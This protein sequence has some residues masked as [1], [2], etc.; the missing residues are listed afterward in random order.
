MAIAPCDKPPPRFSAARRAYHKF[1]Q[2]ALDDIHSAEKSVSRDF[3]KAEQ[4]GART[5]SRLENRL[6]G[7]KSPK[8]S[9]RPA[10]GMLDRSPN[11][12]AA[13]PPEGGVFHG[14][15]EAFKFACKHKTLLEEVAA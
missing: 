7:K 2:A 12:R 3:R 14:I 8:G 1:K 5:F 10:R 6:A 11:H 13:H 15:H 4:W 9:N